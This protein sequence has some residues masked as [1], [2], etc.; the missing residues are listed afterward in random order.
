MP[1]TATRGSTEK[2]AKMYSEKKCLDRLREDEKH[3]QKL[4]IS[5]NR[6]GVQKQEKESEKRVSSALNFPRFHPATREEK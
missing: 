1:T 3:E 6:R 4:G 5:G 2:N